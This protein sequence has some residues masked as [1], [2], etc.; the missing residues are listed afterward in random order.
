MVEAAPRRIRGFGYR[1]QEQVADVTAL[2]F[3]SGT[4]DTGYSLIGWHH[5][6][7]WGQA[8]AEPVRVLAS[9]EVLVGDDHLDGAPARLLSR[10]IARRELRRSPATLPLANIR[11]R[12]STT[13]PHCRASRDGEK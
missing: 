3:P 1:G 4:F 11:V 9:G 6:L 8:R 2:L 5:V 12:E 7:D 10:L 13:I